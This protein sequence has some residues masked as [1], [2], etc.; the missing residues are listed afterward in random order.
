MPATYLFGMR[1]ANFWSLTCV[2][3]WRTKHT[4]LCFMNA[5]KSVL[6]YMICVCLKGALPFAGLL[7]VPLLWRTKRV[8]LCTKTNNKYT[9]MPSI[10]VF[11]THTQ[12]LFCYIGAFLL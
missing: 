6:G 8:Y 12:P 2:S 1:G 9:S 3:V 11:D 7:S 10:D 4:Y 5:N